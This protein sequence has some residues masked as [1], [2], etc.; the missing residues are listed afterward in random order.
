METTR[1]VRGEKN[2]KKNDKKKYEEFGNKERWDLLNTL[3]DIRFEL[4]IMTVIMAGAAIVGIF[5]VL[6]LLHG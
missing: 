4:G 2:M 1:R 6:R 5:A 3:H